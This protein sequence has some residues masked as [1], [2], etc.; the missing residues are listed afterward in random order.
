MMAAQLQRRAPQ[1]AKWRLRPLMT[2]PAGRT[3]RPAKH[4]DAE[5]H[6]AG[7]GLLRCGFV[8][9]VAAED[10][11]AV[12]DDLDRLALRAVGLPVTPFQ[13]AVDRDRAALGG[14]LG[15]VVALGAPDG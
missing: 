2:W 3:A 11:D 5:V 15:G 6:S 4:G 10:L 1:R 14:V 13:A 9:G 7:L 12:G 8:A